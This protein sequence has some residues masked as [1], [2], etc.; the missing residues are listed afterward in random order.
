MVLFHSELLNPHQKWHPS[1]GLVSCLEK[2]L[3]EPE[4]LQRTEQDRQQKPKCLP[5]NIR[6]GRTC[7]LI[8]R[9]Q[10]ELSVGQSDV[11]KNFLRKLWKIVTSLGSE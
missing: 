6:T 7:I 1:P 11:R 2:S 10:K 4:D 9:A 8:A 3:H 5:I